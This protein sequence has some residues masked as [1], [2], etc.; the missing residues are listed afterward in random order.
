MSTAGCQPA[1]SGLSNWPELKATAGSDP[2]IVAS[3]RDPFPDRQQQLSAGFET[4]QRA[5]P[6]GFELVET[7]VT[8]HRSDDF[9]K[10]ALSRFF[11]EFEFF[12]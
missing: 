1:R 9:A 3:L 2:V 4:R 5:I 7:P 8:E 11:A 6:L 12:Q 10:G